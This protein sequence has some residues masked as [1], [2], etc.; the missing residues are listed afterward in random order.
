MPELIPVLKKSDI[1]NMVA[2]VA[3]RI[4]S[5][6]QDHELILIGVLKGAFVFLSDLMLNLSIPVQVDFI[7]VASYGS[8]TSSSGRIN[9][10][11]AVE[12][13][14]KN[15]DVLVVEDIVDT[16]LTLSY[17]IDYLKSFKPKTVKVCTLLDKRQRRQADVKV[18]YACHI[19]T[20]GFLVGYGLDY[21]EDYRNL[22]EIYHL[23]L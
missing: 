3:R 22:P 7:R 14:V 23:Q 6:Y 13:D 17:I 12:I 16:G 2:Q 9:L 20:E 8:D 11:K 21:D 18:D 4:S 15:K 10:T 1:N 5:D 19:V